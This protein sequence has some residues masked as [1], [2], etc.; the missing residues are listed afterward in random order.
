MTDLS[1]PRRRLAER[2]QADAGRGVTTF[3]ATAAQRRIWLLHQLA[4]HSSRYTMPAALRLYGELDV[5]A[6]R[7]ALTAVATRHEALRTVF[8]AVDGIPVQRVHA[9]A[10]LRL[11]VREPNG[12]APV[13]A[14]RSAVA[15]PFDLAAAPPVRAV[16]WP[17][18]PGEHLLLIAVHH[19][20]AD[21]WSLPIL[22]TDLAAAYRGEDG[23]APLPVQCG[24]YAVWEAGADARAQADA[25]AGYWRRALADPPEPADLPADRP[26]PLTEA[27]PA[28]TVRTELPP[29][30]T[31]QLRAHARAARTTVFTVLH[32]GLAAVLHRFTGARDQIIGVPVS[33]R[34]RAETAALAGCFVNTLPLRTRCTAGTGFGALLDQVRDRTREAL[35]HQAAPL[36]RI[37]AEAGAPRVPG[38]APLFDVGI[39]LNPPLDVSGLFAGLRAEVVPLDAADAKFDLGCLIEEDGDTL[40]IAWEYRADLLDA[41]TVGS[42]AACFAALLA[43]GTAEPERPLG[44]L[45]LG[46]AAAE[47]GTPVTGTVVGLFADA[48]AAK[49]GEPAI[50]DGDRTLAYRDLDRLTNRIARALRDRG[51]GPETPVGVCLPRS[52][53]FAVACLAVLKAGGHYVPLDAGQPRERLDHMLADAGIA[54]AISASPV[55]EFL[56]ATS[57]LAVDRPADWAGQPGTAPGTPVHPDTLAAQLFTSGSTGR[58]KAV[59]LTHRGVVDLVRPGSAS[60]LGPDRTLLWLSSVSFDAATW[61]IWG[62]L[63]HGARGVVHPELAFTAEA[64]GA[65]VRAHGVTTAVLATALFHAIVDEDPAAL[66]GLRTVLIGGEALSVPHVQR[67]LAAAPGLTVINGYGP[68]EATTCVTAHAVSE[69]DAGLR[70]LPSVPIGR[71][72]NGSRVE[73]CDAD[74]YPVPPGA[75]GEVWLGGPG[76]ARGYTGHPALT[77]ERFAPGPDGGRRYRTGDL[78]RRLGDGTLLFRGRVD[79]QVKIRGHRV[80]P[81]EIEAVLTRHP[82]V[83]AAAVV[84]HRLSP[85]DTRL[86]AYVVTDGGG[87]LRPWLAEVL[88]SYLVPASLTVVDAL[89]LTRNGKLDPARLPAPRWAGHAGPGRARTG[90]EDA[91]ARIW[92]DLLELD[93]ATLGPGDDF[94]DLGG[95]SL[96]A[97]RLVSRLAARLGA[98]VGLAEVF[99]HTTLAA[100]ADV[101][102]A[103]RPAPAAGAIEPG[104]RPAPLSHAQERLWFLARLEPDSPA[105]HLPLSVRIGGPLD[106]ARLAA[107]WDTVMARHETLRSVV[108]ERDGGLFAVPAAP[109]ALQ[110]A[111]DAGDLARRP[112]DLAREVPIRALL[113]RT[114]EHEHVLSVVVHHIAADGWSVAILAEEL[115]AAYAGRELGPVV[116]YGDFAHWQ[117]N[118]LTGAALESLTAF[119]R[120]TTDGAP[121]VLEL[122]AD[123][124]RPPRQSF[125]GASAPVTIPA[126]TAARIRTLAASAGCTEFMVLSAAFAATLSAYSGQRDVLFGTPVAG[127]PHPDV[128]R[129]VG[130]F[131][132]T[133]VLRADLSGE[134]TARELLARLRRTCLAAFAH[135]DL[136][137]EKLVEALTPERDLSRNPVVQTMLALNTNTPPR[138]DLAGTAVR[139]LAAELPV[140]RFDLA[141]WL[142]DGDDGGIGGF[143]EYDTALF[144]RETVSGMLAHFAELLT[145]MTADPDVVLE[146]VLT[147]ADARRLRTWGDGSAALAGEPVAAAVARIAAADPDR[148]AIAAED[149]SVRTYGQLW[150]AA[151]GVAARLRS[152]GVA[153]GA[154]VG[155]CAGR[156]ASTVAALLGCGL[157]GAAYVPLDPAAPAARLARMAELAGLAVVLADAESAGRVRFAPV[158]PLDAEPDGGPVAPYVSE[159]DGPAYVLFTSG[160]TGEPKGVTVPHPA[161]TAF[162]AAMTG[163]E[164]GL[165]ARSRLVAVTPFTFD[166]AALEIFGPLTCGACVTLAEPATTHDGV[167]LARLLE[168]ADCDVLQ[169][170]P[171]TWRLLLDAGWRPW[172]GFRALCGGEALPAGLAAELREHGAELWNLYGPTETTV[173]STAGRVDD[174]GRIGIGRPIP[175]TTLELTTATG[176]PV[177]VG[178]VGEIRLSGAGLA[179]GYA[180]RPGATAERFVPG[181]GGKRRYRTGDLARFDHSGR[182]HHLG[183]ADAQLKIRGHRVEPAEAEAALT[184]HP[185]V[186]AAAVVAREGRLV[187]Y[188]LADP[189]SGSHVDPAVLKTH[190]S[191]LLPG[192]LIPD[193]LLPSAEFPVTP[194]GK[195]D[196]TALSAAPIRPS[197]AD[198]GPRDGL[199]AVVAEICSDVLG[200]PLAAGDDFFAAGGHSLDAARAATRL[201]AALGVEIPVLA[202]F[203][204]PGP[205]A[206]AGWARARTAG[207]AD[208][209]PVLP[210]DGPFPLSSA[211]ERLWF[212]AEYAPESPAYNVPVA[213]RLT[214]PLDVPALHR[215]LETVV[216]RHPAL[217]TVFADDGGRGVQRHLPTAEAALQIVDLTPADL[218]GAADT[219]D[220]GTQRSRPASE[221][222]QQTAAPT[223]DPD[224]AERAAVLAAAAAT[225]PFRLAAGEPPFRAT[226]VRISGQ[227]HVLVLVLHHIVADGW[228][229]SVLARDLAAAY[230]GVALPAPVLRHSDYAAWQRGRAARAAGQ[231][232]RR[233]EEL[234]GAPH[235][236]E[237]PADWPRPPERRHHGR[238]LPLAAGPGL[239]ERVRALARDTGVTEFMVLLAAFAATLTRFNGQEDLLIGTPAAQRTAPGTADVVGLFA[240]TLVVRARTGGDP[241]V[242]ELLARVRRAC[243]DAYAAP[244]VAFETLVDA[245]APQRDPTRSP[246]FQVMIA[247][248]DTAGAL[249][250]LPGLLVEPVPVPNRTAKFDVVLNLLDTPGGIEGGCEFD[251]DVYQEPLMARFTEHYLRTLHEFT[252]GPDRPLSAI[253][254]LSPAEEQTWLREF[255]RVPARYDPQVCL[256]TL[257]EARAA[258]TPEAVAVSLATEPGRP[259]PRLTYAE[260]EDRANRL[261]RHLV[262]RG[263]RPDDV[264]GVALPRSLEAVVAQYA[265]LKAGAG[266]LPLDPA[267]PAARL[268]GIL[269]DAGAR[270]VVTDAD[271]DG[272]LPPEPGRVRLDRAEWRA[273]DASPPSVAVGPGHLA[274]VVYTSGSTG[275]PKGVQI[276]HRAIANNLLWMQ[277]D[278]PLTAADRM[279]HKTTTTFDVAVKE[280]FWPLL[281]GA[282]LVLAK[283]GSQRDPDYLVELIAGAGITVT[284]FVPSMLELAVEALDAAG[285]RFPDSLRYVMCGAE[286]LPVATQEAFFAH[287]SA[288]LLHMYGPTETAIAVTGWTCKRAQ[289]RG[290]VPLGGPMPLVELYVLDRHGRPVPPGVWGELHVGGCSLGRGYLGRPAETAAAFVPDPFSGREGARLY[291][292]GDVVRHGPDGLLEFR[293]RADDQIKIRGFRV[294]LGEIEAA[295]AAEP[296]V[297]QA[298]AVLRGRGADA[299]LIGYAVPA[300]GTDLD[301]AD[302]RRRLRTRLPDYMVPADVVVLTAMPLGDNA[303]VDRAALPD[304]APRGRTGPAAAPRDA[305]EAAVAEVWAEFLGTG[306]VGV[307][308]DFFVL[309]GNSL[310]AA[311]IAARLRER[312]ACELRLRDVFVEPTVAGIARLLRAAGRT[313]AIT[314]QH[315]R[316]RPA[317]PGGTP[318]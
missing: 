19:I 34:T 136:P 312:F 78:A 38:R 273:E 91:V 267:Q 204:H 59:A 70:E 80:E 317:H 209:V 287:G 161:L 24:D 30:L 81:G 220:P 193:L 186:P 42:I 172:P 210:G 118:R 206:L 167:A 271:G 86:A 286:T 97:S 248:N 177:P 46:P 63:L 298:A 201:S 146:T 131:A 152:A 179:L 2:L 22:L 37:I 222:A 153:P 115:G 288:D 182:L 292:T 169:G 123:R 105:Y 192:Y 155:I 180:A 187:G 114:G 90:T 88:P 113:A 148:P 247:L 142:A 7:R 94:F 257:V 207:P 33:G 282:E 171:A 116:Q 304:P 157:A 166:I 25:A 274:Y 17:V 234:A 44:A 56:A 43:A 92:A 269:A 159:V 272:V 184:A 10:D 236:L 175:G 138:L 189:V 156:S 265:I 239:T 9:R 299:R 26:R 18:A 190:L 221:A 195:L 251:T 275:K 35:T 244:D 95:H 158:L 232:T 67:A 79:A 261:A 135:Q 309:G 53:D 39:T 23:R 127:R 147:D 71:A 242:R 125:D 83:A 268:A 61:E 290:R 181:E 69:V 194:H 311:R 300:P 104:P 107:A 303:K 224:P 29:E 15:D 280:V 276:D 256:H 73:L 75:V 45:P 134:P 112:F 291:R 219:D 5:P 233:C 129:T 318:S 121:L 164:P 308:D 50:V 4:P 223:T 137:F 31:R 163:H 185:G 310:Q 306:A 96:L 314:R 214:G 283:P 296:D 119:W 270:L 149:G 48:V 227:D 109:A 6:L 293:G 11:E 255:N 196:R 58:P 140:A 243:L 229:V 281:A 117:R 289:S 284:H 102:A 84:S 231:L 66:R 262:R 144:D 76:L 254:A 99:T 1:V 173:W 8:P 212:L 49:P 72:V 216:A 151:T 160:S 111:D 41:A 62:T 295:L 241:A 139:P 188:Y 40:R 154:A 208:P 294:E 47:P 98:D 54:H 183:R 259:R 174:S 218:T 279:L 143:A 246:L 213:A 252:A 108:E 215:A 199:E 264:V 101:V 297:R 130:S 263:V 197:A 77:A 250:E 124:P 103:A 225:R 110:Y 301:P 3:P 14:L 285:R 238:T 200:R 278:W 100:L 132:N 203:E 12:V 27:G 315:R 237:L 13:D 230:A 176:A 228:S 202:V 87:D 178:A 28:A 150:R 68:A 32:A 106:T 120:S 21:A 65:A 89:P 253:G 235:T 170:T 51:V 245:M 20:A 198:L 240:E 133:V 36:E 128:E 266:F 126:G 74:G 226:L 82:A 122:P 165:S 302:L 258:A 52:A 205:A 249:P 305:F 168:A 145:A 260:L 191:T 64:I 55:P 307:D 16:L 211:Q 277:Q 141:L 85:T 60:G 313:T 217:R 57:T 162:L 93:P 316:A